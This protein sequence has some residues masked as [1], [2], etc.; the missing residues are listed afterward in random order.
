MRQPC[1][2]ARPAT[3]SS[4]DRPPGQIHVWSSAADDFSDVAK[5][6]DNVAA[7]DW[8]P[9]IAETG[10]ALVLAR[11]VGDPGCLLNCKNPDRR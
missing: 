11:Q 9:G 8:A 10:G 2:S 5:I 6:S 3:S 7:S 4:A 1:R